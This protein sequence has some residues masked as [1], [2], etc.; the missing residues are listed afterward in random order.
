MDYFG[1]GA[2]LVVTNSTFTRS[3]RDKASRLHCRLVD[4]QHIPRLIRG[5]VL[6][7]YP[8]AGTA[9]CPHC[10][11]AIPFSTKNCGTP[12][13]CPHCS[14]QFIVPQILFSPEERFRQAR[15]LINAGDLAEGYALI[16]KLLQTH[17]WF[18]SPMLYLAENRFVHKQFPQAL[19][20][21]QKAMKLGSCLPITYDHAAHAACQ[22]GSFYFARQLLDGAQRRVGKSKFTVRMWVNY[23]RAAAQ[24][25][26]TKEALKHLRRAAKAGETDPA[27]YESDLLLMPLREERAFQRFL[28]RLRKGGFANK[29]SLANKGYSAGPSHPAPVV[30]QVPQCKGPPEG[31]GAHK[32]RTPL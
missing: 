4:K 21:Y 20:L 26:E 28:T 11:K 31:T 22:S 9:Q 7:R 32:P 5:E 15:Q 23:A 13:R 27:R 12:A 16:K 19:K 3:A 8:A 29:G 17:P 25:Q 24:V 30:A 18:Q 10:R 2:S 6:P 1:C 14:G